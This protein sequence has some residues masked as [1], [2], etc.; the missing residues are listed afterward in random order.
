MS[1]WALCEWAGGGGRDLETRRCEKVPERWTGAGSL[2]K[3]ASESKRGSS[4]DVGG[5]ASEI[6]CWGEVK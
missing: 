3:I 5:S 4:K 6:A 1:G 2:L